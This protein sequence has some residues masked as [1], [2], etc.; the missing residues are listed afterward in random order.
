MN[1]NLK[2]KVGGTGMF[3]KGLGGRFVNEVYGIISGEIMTTFETNKLPNGYFQKGLGHFLGNKKL[4]DQGRKM[5]H[6]YRKRQNLRNK[7]F[8]MLTN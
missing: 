2:I 4:I 3:F 7:M 6:Q 1:R 5:I 8:E